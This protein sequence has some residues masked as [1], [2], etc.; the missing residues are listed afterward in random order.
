MLGSAGLFGLIHV[1][2]AG[3]GVSFYRVPFAF[4]V[5]LGLGVLLVR[6]GSLVLPMLA[7]GT[8]NSIT[9]LAAIPLAGQEM[10]REP[11]PYAALGLP[12]LA[13]GSLAFAF[14][15]RRLEKPVNAK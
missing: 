6:T 7:H 1:M 13:L 2:P 9:F 12:L 15:L 3:H 4:F 8:L 5:G 10:S 11:D 14:L